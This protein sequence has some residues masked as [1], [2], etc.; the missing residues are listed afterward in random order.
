MNEWNR[1]SIEQRIR[2]MFVLKG[3]VAD[4]FLKT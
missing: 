3:K 1:Y 4:D 2:L